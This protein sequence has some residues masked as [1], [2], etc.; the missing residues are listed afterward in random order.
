MF[1]RSSWQRQ[2]FR[3]RSSRGGQSFRSDVSAADLRLESDV[4]TARDAA[5]RRVGRPRQSRSLPAVVR[6]VSRDDEGGAGAWARGASSLP[7]PRPSRFS[8]RW[9][10]LS[11]CRFRSPSISRPA[12]PRA[13]PT[14]AHR[15]RRASLETQHRGA[16]TFLPA[17]S[18]IRLGHPRTVPTLPG[19]VSRRATARPRRAPRVTDGGK[20]A[21]RFRG[22]VHAET[23]R[24]RRTIGSAAGI[25]E[26]GQSRRRRLFLDDGTAGSYVLCS[27]LCSALYSARACPRS[28]AAR[29]RNS[30]SSVVRGGSSSQVR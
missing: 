13:A 4:A 30:A 28:G 26:R 21:R 6:H 1:T 12:L 9:S 29:A 17:R 15:D 18:T 5:L 16:R 3:P 7:R 14:A 24:R 23:V 2:H 10:H 22:S 8:P 11:R 19:C 27:A 25:V 20:S